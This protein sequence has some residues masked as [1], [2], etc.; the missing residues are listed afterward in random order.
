MGQGNCYRCT[1]CDYEFTAYLGVGFAFP[2]VYKD[3]MESARKGELG[4]KIQQFMHEHPDGA[5][6]CESSIIRCTKCGALDCAPN[7]GMY[8]P[9]EGYDPHSVQHGQWS[10]AM[11]F[12]GESYVTPW[13][14]RENYKLTAKYPHKC[15]KC[16]AS[17]RVI[18]AKSL[19][20]K[21]SEGSI[22]CPCCGER[23]DV[24]E[25]VIIWD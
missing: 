5:L 15:D 14:L 21:I 2:Q 20:N 12:D 10:G 13:E 22:R 25:C 4:E 19:S 8:L 17:A 24:V 23:M 6:N 16:G 11:P 3:M 7:L 1:K 18:S 9:K